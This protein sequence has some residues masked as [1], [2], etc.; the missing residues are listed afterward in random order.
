MHFVSVSEA[1]TATWPELSTGEVQKG[2]LNRKRARSTHGG[3]QPR[4]Q[5][6][7][8]LPQQQKQHWYRPGTVT[9]REIRKYQKSTELLICKLPFQCLVWD[10]LQ[11]INM[12]LWL[13][14][15]T[16]MTLQEAAEAYLVQLLEDSNLHAIHARCITIL[17]KDMQLARQIHGERS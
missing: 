14:P 8:Q 9:L 16:V 3:K 10:I 5:G 2:R 12:H 11:G 1:D 7:K 15:A 17:V 4:S 6:G 13:T